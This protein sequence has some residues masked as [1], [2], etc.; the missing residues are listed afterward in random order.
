MSGGLVNVDVGGVVREV[1][2]VIDNVWTS[3]E[4]R[5]NAEWRKLELEAAPHLGQVATNKQEATHK[6]WF[7][8]GWRPAVGWVIALAFLYALIIEPL[9]GWIFAVFLPD[10]QPPPQVDGAQLVSIL[11][12]ML[13]LGGMRTWEKW[14]GV[15]SSSIQ[16]P[17]IA[18]HPSVARSL[19]E[20]RGGLLDHE[21]S[22]YA[23]P[24]SQIPDALAGDPPKTGLPLS[25]SRRAQ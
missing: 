18:I 25:L 24:I 19:S 20:G 21:P 22:A 3:D 5:L 11:G 13:G 1:G 4:E 23:A 6:A 14:K 10:V 15:A 12:M 7:V 9:L 8:A 16:K 2:G 17:K